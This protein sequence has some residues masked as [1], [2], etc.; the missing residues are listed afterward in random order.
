MDGWAGGVLVSNQTERLVCLLADVR[1][2]FASCVFPLGSPPLLRSPLFVSSLFT[3]LSLL[4]VVFP[5]VVCC[6]TAAPCCSSF[7]LLFC[8]AGV[9]CSFFLCAGLIYQLRGSTCVSIS[10]PS[11]ILLFS[12][13]SRLC[14]FL[15]SLTDSMLVTCSGTTP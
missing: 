3:T 1:L 4:W 14:H 6:F 8:F 7:F 10:G 5:V 13:P 11:G 2:L 12:S 15:R 9:G